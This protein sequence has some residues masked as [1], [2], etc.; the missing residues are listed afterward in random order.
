M[1]GIFSKLTGFERLGW[2]VAYKIKR[3]FVFFCFQD[4]WLQREI[5]KEVLWKD[6]FFHK[7]CL[8]LQQNLRTFQKLSPKGGIEETNDI[9]F[10]FFLIFFLFRNRIVSKNSFLLLN[11]KLD[12]VSQSLNQ[13]QN[14]GW[15]KR[16]VCKNI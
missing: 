13:V 5:W 6:V 3:C 10:Q 8:A 11:R 2:K 14:T 7:H 1:L 16:N 15:Q 12:I 4:T 9:L